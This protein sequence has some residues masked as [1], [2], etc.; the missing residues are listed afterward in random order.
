MEQMIAESARELDQALRSRAPIAPLSE[1][2]PGLTPAQS[3]AIQS[4]WLELLRAEG[5]QVVGQ[6][7]GLT[8]KA[9]QEQL[10]V[11]E[12]DYGFILDRMVVASGSSLPRSAFLLPR[13]EPEIAFWLGEDL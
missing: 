2:Y 7:I 5:A 11:H 8:S 12:P 9:M 4:A 3:Y 10:G 1:R 13:V 6:K